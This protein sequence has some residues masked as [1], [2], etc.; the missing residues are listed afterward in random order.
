VGRSVVTVTELR[1]HIVSRK[2]A[3]LCL[4]ALTLNQIACRAAEPA[5]L[6]LTAMSFN[7]RTGLAQDGENSWD[8]RKD[9]VFAVIARADPDI[10]ALQEADV[11][12]LEEI[13][14]SVPGYRNA[15]SED[16]RFL[17]DPTSILYR[18]ERFR[19]EETGFF[20]LSDTPETPSSSWGN[21][22]A[23]KCSWARL[24]DLRT[25][26][27]FY[28]Y[29]THL[30][31]GSRKSREKSAVLMVERIIGRTH[32]DPVI[33]MGDFNAGEESA[34]IKTIKGE[35]VRSDPEA[36]RLLDSFRVLHPNE[37]EVGTLT[38]FDFGNTDG[39]KIDYVFV[40]PTTEV[41]E[42]SVIRVHRDRR[43]PSDHFPVSARLRLHYS[44]MESR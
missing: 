43:Y 23:R 33:L 16:G 4:L 8:N 24:I 22:L 28:V 7:I 3:L 1:G 6:D 32:P 25:G 19:L 17:N 39:K 36:F 44:K 14:Q 42:S 37:T 27:A 12:Q 26:H 34:T 30:D 11:R 18:S 29:N 40:E 31:N 5:S 21:R 41:F 10:L 13:D 35:P 9:H 2:T 15:L 20:W 38:R